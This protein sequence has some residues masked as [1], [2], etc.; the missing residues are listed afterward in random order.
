MR[1]PPVIAPVTVLPAPLAGLAAAALGG[2]AA[3]ARAMWLA[4]AGR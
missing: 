2:L 1:W 4:R 3:V